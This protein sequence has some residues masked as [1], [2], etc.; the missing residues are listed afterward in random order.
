MRSV[1]GSQPDKVKV[2][3]KT[4]I[5]VQFEF[6][7]PLPLNI[8]PAFVS[9]IDFGARIVLYNIDSTSKSNFPTL[10]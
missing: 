7:D 5:S 1:A 10:V 3:V 4:L 6:A 9:H 8:Q 2:K